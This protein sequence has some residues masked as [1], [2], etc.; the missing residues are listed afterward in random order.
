[1]MRTTQLALAVLL[2]GVVAVSVS[3]D[4]RHGK[5]NITKECSHYTG[6]AGS[7]CTITSSN[8]AE[9][10]AGSTVYYTQAA[11]DPT[12]PEGSAIGLDSNV[13]VFVTT[14]D[15]A[16]GRCTLGVSF[17]GLCTFSDGV[18]ALAGFHGHVVVTPTGGPNFSWV[19]TY[20]FTGDDDQ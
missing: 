10:P 11:V 15:W 13:V 5:V 18:G 3:A 17:Q 20:G 8:V 9:I 4:G 6:S 19:G 12:T 16:T 7:Y 1:M 2:A 14:G